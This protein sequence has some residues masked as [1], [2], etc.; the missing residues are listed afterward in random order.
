MQSSNDNVYISAQK[1]MTVRFYAH[2]IAKR[3][4]A[5]ALV[6]SGAT[7]NFINLSYVRWLKLPI[8]QLP[9][10]QK[11]FN[12]DGTT[13]K[14][15]KLKYYTDLDVQ[16][17]TNWSKLC[18][19][20]IDLGENKAILGYSWFAVQPKI[21]WKC[22]WINASQLPIILRADNTKKARFTPRSVNKPCPLDTTHYFIGKV[23]IGS[24]EVTDKLSIPPEYQ[25]HAKIFSKQESQWLPKHTV[26]DHTIELLSSALDTLPRWLLLLTQ[27]KIE[28]ARKFIEEH[29]KWNTIRP[30]WS[31]YAANFFFVKKKDGKLWPI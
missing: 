18:F 19:F 28:E 26:W 20:L 11:I 27:A 25:R 10:P 29:L 13:N 9:Q 22:R 5:V 16:T 24:T 8:Q 12:I 23:T 1:S 3:V 7:E 21:D 14:S 4:E 31:L 17:S 2:L 15:G 30:S 6:D